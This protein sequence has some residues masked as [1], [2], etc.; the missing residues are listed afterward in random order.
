MFRHLDSPW[1]RGVLLGLGLLF[2][3]FLFGSP[4]EPGGR[5]LPA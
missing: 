4:D 2:G 1:Q 3:G 5:R